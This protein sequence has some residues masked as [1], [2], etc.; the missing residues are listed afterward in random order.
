M[1]L[2]LII[3]SLCLFLAGSTGHAQHF[4]GK[5][6]DEVRKLMAEQNQELFEDESA[7]N[8]A[9]NMI[10]YTDQLGN[11]TMIFVFGDDDRCMYTKLMCDYS[12]LDKMQDNLDGNY[13]KAND[14]L[15]TYSHDGQVYS[16]SL[17][18][19]EWYFVL[20]TRKKED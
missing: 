4:I 12:L 20:D 8:T 9:I 14:S 6:K 18:M 19:K 16:I 3:F 7:R 17:K 13:S 10:K 2:K 5:P 1:K 15:W 11:Q